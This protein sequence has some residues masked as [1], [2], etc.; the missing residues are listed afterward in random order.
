MRKYQWLLKL[1]L[2][3]FIFALTRT[4]ISCSISPYF[5]K[6]D[7][8]MLKQFK[9]IKATLTKEIQGCKALKERQFSIELTI[10]GPH[11]EECPIP[12]EI[13]TKHGIKFF[14]I[15]SKA[16]PERDARFI[17]DPYQDRVLIVT[18]YSETG[19]WD[20]HVREKGYLYSTLPLIKSNI[21]EKSLDPIVTA[22][23]VTPD[24]PRSV[25]VW[26]YHQIEANWYLYFRF[27]SQKS[28]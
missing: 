11:F 28:I 20:R 14:G 15:E 19:L 2:F 5:W 27:H 25:R 1:F 8:E 6:K 9:D 10:G 7:S 13:A 18:D 12:K 26:R 4:T 3:L 17:D 22:E 24:G 21:M 23:Y 16:D